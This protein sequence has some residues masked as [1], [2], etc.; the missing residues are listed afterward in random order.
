MNWE[1]IVIPNEEMGGEIPVTEQALKARG[2]KVYRAG[3]P[4]CFI[5]DMMAAGDLPDLFYSENILLARRLENLH[6][7][8]FTE[9]CPEAGSCLHFA[10]IDTIADIYVNG[11]LERS[12]DNM[13]MPV[14][15]APRWQE[16]K[17]FVV[18]HI[19]PPG[20]ESRRYPLPASSV[21]SYYIQEALNIRK[22][23]LSFGW[24]ISPRILTAGL[25]APV[26]LET[27]KA[28]RIDDV[29]IVTGSID[30]KKRTA[31]LR[32]Y[33]QFT[34]QGDFANDYT[35][36][37]AGRCKDSY[38]EKSSTVWHTSHSFFLDAEDVLL[39]SPK[40]YG[41]PHLYDVTVTLYRRGRPADERRLTYGIRTT[42]LLH[43][44]KDFRFTVNEESIFVM[45]TNWVPTSVFAHEKEKRLGRA[46]EL[47][48]ESGANMVRIWGGGA[49]E[50]DEFYEFCDRNGILVWQDFMMACAIYPQEKQFYDRIAAEAEYEIRRLRN[51][52]SIVLWCGDN[53]CDQTMAGWSDFVRDPADNHITRRVLPSVLKTHDYT[54]PYI[55][56][57]PYLYSGRSQNT[58]V[59]RHL[60]TRT[61]H[62]ASPFFLDTT[63][64]FISEI[65]Y[66]AFP[67]VQSLKKFLREPQRIL[68]ED[69]SATDEYRLHGTAPELSKKAWYDHKVPCACLFASEM[70]SPLSEDLETFVLQSQYTQA[71][72]YK[73]WVENAR[74][75]GLGG[76]L[77]WNLLDGWPQ[78]SEA[79]VDYYWQKKASFS[80]VK[81]AQRPV[82]VI[83]CRQGPRTLQY[84]AV[85]DTARDADVFYEIGSGGN[86]LREGRCTVRAGEAK[87][88]GRL[89]T[90]GKSNF[91][92]IRFEVGGESFLSHYQE[93]PT[94]LDIDVYCANIIGTYG[95]EERPQA[96]VA[97]AAI[98]QPYRGFSEKRRKT[99]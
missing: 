35:V 4:G 42:R 39:W 30:K 28:D 25:Y 20:I 61:E 43:E 16:G 99:K 54:R 67:C 86:V 8:Y 14:D 68:Q 26:T 85:N 70:F 97:A 31:R 89:E 60:W 66:I 18:V 6:V 5:T 65:G 93:N 11:K 49:Y 71:E 47:L 15:V 46:L 69:G 48:A 87:L 21:S 95:G 1:F 82:S 52:C 33:F 96:E 53:E 2:A 51:H 3:V 45:G 10:G 56:S 73:T 34:L 98:R 74:V 44:G 62:F 29:F 76:I 13:F 64:R 12:C 75:K 80:F 17:N 57:S 55:P 23:V 79:M 40:N 9:I 72:A 41:E 36:R 91:Y 37:I 81:N 92:V 50:Q 24:D 19:K 22:P 59:E 94:G 78:V 88:L 38:F 84:F 27:A 90:D 58:L 63:A 32:V 7:F 83:L 77:L